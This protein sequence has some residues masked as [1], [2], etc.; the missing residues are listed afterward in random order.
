MGVVS[1]HPNPF[2]FQPA[3]AGEFVGR[4]SLVDEMEL[5]VRIGHGSF[6]C[7]GGRRFGK[8]SLLTVLLERLQGTSPQCP[9][10]VVVPLFVDPTLNNLASPE[11]FFGAVLWALHARTTDSEPHAST[12][13]AERRVSLAGTGIEQV[14]KDG[15]PEVSAAGFAEIVSRVFER[16]EH[17]G[18]PQRLVLL[19]DE[20]DSLLDYPWHKDLLA[21]LRAILVALRLRLRVVLAGSHH[22]LNEVTDRGSP[23]VNMLD[24]R[25]LVSLDRSSINLMMDRAVGLREP[26]R[27]AV[28]KYAGGHPFLVQYL[29]RS[30]WETGPSRA[31]AEH[32]ASAADRFP[33][34]GSIHLKG[35]IAALGEA[36]LKTYDIFA[37]SDG[38]LARAEI[39]D[40]VAEPDVVGSL[41]ALS[42]HGFIAPNEK[43][44]TYRRNGD[45]F[46]DWFLQYSLH[47]AGSAGNV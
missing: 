25:Y 34:Q 27:R 36:G 43:W 33:Q 13:S 15:R 30:V 39:M 32:V 8:T 18:G 31:S 9:T 24:L 45:L 4:W 5:E 35:W 1:K 17:V 40:R 11:A 22:F 19:V 2:H 29:L 42:Y 14:F 26:A 12:G 46:R 23:L 21:Q 28:W 16:L 44:T 3:T 10:S 6:A 47:Q 20:M 7:I 37:R 41:T 38:A